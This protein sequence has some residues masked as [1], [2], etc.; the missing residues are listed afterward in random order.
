MRNVY[1]PVMRSLVER[2]EDHRAGW[3][4]LHRQLCASEFWNREPFSRG[5]AWIDLLL[6]ASHKKHSRR[7]RGIKIDLEPGQLA[8]SERALA[9][10]WQ[11]SRGKV[12]R[13]L[14]ELQDEQM[15]VPQKNNVCTVVTLV[16]YLEFQQDGPQTVPQ[17]EPQTGPQ[18]G[19]QTVPRYKNGKNGKNEKELS[20]PFAGESAE[21]EPKK[22]RNPP[23]KG[24][25]EFEAAWMAYGPKGSKPLS[26]AE[27][28]KLSPED[29]VRISKAIPLRDEWLRS[30]FEG[31]KPADFERFL[32]RRTFDT[33]AE[34]NNAMYDALP[35][36]VKDRGY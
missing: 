2:S 32:K 16:K 13:F 10:R 15:V 18:T 36:E 29:H 20:L 11:W 34:W 5:Q 14:D 19:P 23:T 27:W 12:R 31:R 1:S 17:T 22:K 4:K 8:W 9:D 21:P 25:P 28:K 33:I 35:Q 26:W 24:T 7:V 3:I 30:D 6:M